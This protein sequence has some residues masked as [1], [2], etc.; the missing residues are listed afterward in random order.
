MSMPAQGRRRWSRRCPSLLFLGS[1]HSGNNVDI[2]VL[3][4][5]GLKSS[6]SCRSRFTAYCRVDFP[7]ALKLRIYTTNDEETARKGENRD[8]VLNGKTR[9]TEVTRGEH[10]R[11]TEKGDTQIFALG[12]MERS[13]THAT[14]A[15][16]EIILP[17]T[18]VSMISTHQGDS[19]GREG[20]THRSASTLPLCV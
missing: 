13:L 5:E 11:G 9:P 16:M 7:M 14:G 8:E 18:S 17:G 1:I 2:L 4:W 10:R 19:M 20:H 15:L 3:V 12:P 6:S